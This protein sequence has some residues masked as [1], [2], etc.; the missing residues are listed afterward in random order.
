MSCLPSE[1]D[2]LLPE[3][4]SIAQ[5][6]VDDL[7]SAEKLTR[8]WADAE[9]TDALVDTALS[10]CLGRPGAECWGEANRVPSGEL[11]VA[12]SLLEVGSLQYQARFKPHGCAGDHEML[13]R[14]C[15]E[16]CCDHPLGRAFDRFF[17]RQA[18]PQAVRA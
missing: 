17:L 1:P 10:E 15:Q 8:H 2:G 7:G 6:L 9:L 18:A 14:I 5:R 3:V 13:A 16:T 4:G 11:W 12:G